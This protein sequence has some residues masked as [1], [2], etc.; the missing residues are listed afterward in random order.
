[1]ETPVLGELDRPRILILVGSATP[2]AV[3]REE[4][5]ERAANLPGSHRFISEVSDV[6]LGEW[7]AMLS[8]NG[9]IVRGP[10]RGFCA[11]YSPSDVIPGLRVTEHAGLHVSS[12]NL[13]DNEIA[14]DL[15]AVLLPFANAQAKE[16]SKKIFWT[17]AHRAGELKKVSAGPKVG[18]VT[19]LSTP[20]GDPMV[21]ALR[22]ADSAANEWIVV[23][24]RVDNSFDWFEACLVRWNKEDPVSFPLDT[25]RE[26][27]VWMTGA[28]SSALA[29]VNEVEAR[30]RDALAAL[31]AELKEAS[32]ELA[33]LA[34]EANSAERRLLTESADPLK[35]AVKDALERLGFDVED[36]D[37]FAKQ[38]DRELLEDL[39]VTMQAHPGWTALVE[40]KGKNRAT[41]ANEVGSSFRRPCSRF[42]EEN[43]RQ[44]DALWFVSNSE[45]QKD[46]S[47]RKRPLETSG[48]DLKD[49]SD[50]GGLL[51][52]SVDLFR[53]IRAVDLDEIS[54]EDA[55]S[56]FV[57]KTGPMELPGALD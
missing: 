9:R 44:P 39:R 18:R 23:A 56:L 55:R 1:M 48:P 38:D 54:V 35:A 45:R 12:P 5:E 13:D 21:L 42:A 11:D 51:I 17:R 27:E 57:D 31:D 24:A 10:L 30:R 50:D 19:V 43:G 36:R 46:P 41:S 26:S 3:E 7:D 6:N 25:W 16:P 34:K 22:S 2:L 32:A 28:E 4:R 20:S 53:L 15:E 14:A 37:E 47:S 40:V 8:L 33:A 52:W 29:N 49:F